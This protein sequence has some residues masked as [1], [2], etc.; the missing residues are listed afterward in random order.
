MKKKL[1]LFSAVICFML[2]GISQL[3]AQKKMGPEFST[4]KMEVDFGE[5]MQNGDGVR[6]FKFTNSGTEPLLITNAQGSC[7]CTIPEWPKDPIMP[8]K[9]NVIKIKY[10]TSRIGQINKTVTV[11]TNEV[12]GKDGNGNPIY[13][14]HVIQVK[15]NIKQP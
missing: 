12:E 14:N 3:T 5:V 11:T 15:G 6:E 1:T 8:G 2:L 4:S 10:D 7:G 13:K 9:S